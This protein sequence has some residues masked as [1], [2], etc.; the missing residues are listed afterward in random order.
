MNSG[1]GI[2]LQIL[3]RYQQTEITTK[4]FKCINNDL[5]LKKTTGSDD[6]FANETEHEIL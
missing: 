1:T 6:K 2:S 4:V 3:L 5:A